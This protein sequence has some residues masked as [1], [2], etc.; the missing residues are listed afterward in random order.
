MGAEFIV[1]R[2]VNFILHVNRSRCGCI[3]KKSRD[4]GVG[5]FGREVSIEFVVS[6]N[7]GWVVWWGVSKQGLGEPVNNCCVVVVRCI[8]VIQGAVA[9]VPGT[10]VGW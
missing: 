6:V 3:T 5:T 7:Q 8:V 9:G 2:R 4:C 1:N 10:W